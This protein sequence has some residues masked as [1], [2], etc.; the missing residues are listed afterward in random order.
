VI[1]LGEPLRKARVFAALLIVCG[2]VLIRL[3]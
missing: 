1:W 2:L 3:Q